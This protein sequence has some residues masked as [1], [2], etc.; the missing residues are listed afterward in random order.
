MLMPCAFYT[1]IENRRTLTIRKFRGVSI[2]RL[3]ARI[4][5]IQTN[6]IGAKVTFA[7]GAAL[8]VTVGL[9]AFSIQ[10]LGAVNAA[11][12]EVRNE[13]LPSTALMGQ[14]ASAVEQYRILESVYL[15][16]ASDADTR[17]RNEAAM[18]D[19][20]GLIQKLRND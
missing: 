14:L 20:Q 15:L 5:G 10:R 9:G 6:S 18:R 13:W 4:K 8:I 17:K 16:S 1:G 12:T 11:A 19:E 3:Y 2:S 7:F